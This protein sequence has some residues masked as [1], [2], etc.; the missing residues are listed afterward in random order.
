MG[1]FLFWIFVCGAAFGLRRRFSIDGISN[2]LAG[3]TQYH[4]S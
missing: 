4:Y 3:S 1:I 2:G